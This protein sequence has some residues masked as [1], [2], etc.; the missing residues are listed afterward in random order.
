MSMIWERWVSNQNQTRAIKTCSGKLVVCLRVEVIMCVC[1]WTLECAPLCVR[2]HLWFAVCTRVSGPEGVT[3]RNFSLL[4]NSEV[5]VKTYGSHRV[6]ISVNTTHAHKH[7]KKLF[8]WVGKW[9]DISCITCRGAHPAVPLGTIWYRQRWFIAN[10][11]QSSDEFA[12]SF[13][14][15][16]NFF[17][18]QLE[19]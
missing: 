16:W 13:K 9:R 8:I 18:L 15:T 5:K 1:L 2:V 7:P 19:H 14:T 4:V 17:F 6:M 12:V 10:H 11:W 3:Q